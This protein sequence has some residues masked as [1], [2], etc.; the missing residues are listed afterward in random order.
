MG[1]EPPE[2]LRELA[3]CPCLVRAGLRQ[4]RGRL[5]DGRECSDGAQLPQS[6]S[7]PGAAAQ[8]AG[9]QSLTPYKGFI[10]DRWEEGMPE[11]PATVAGG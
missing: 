8:I 1:P 6:R 4:E 3:A 11:C 2:T 7:L 10:L 9:K 5:A